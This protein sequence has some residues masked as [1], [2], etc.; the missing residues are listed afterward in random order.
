M[1]RTLLLQ[2]TISASIKLTVSFFLAVFV[3]STLLAQA[4]VLK[5]WDKR[6]G[7][8]D[9]DG[10]ESIIST[11][12]GGYLVGGRS[13][14]TNDGDKTEPETTKGE[15]DYWVVKLNADGTKAWD[16]TYG[17]TR[18]DNLTA[19]TTTS[20]GGYLLGGYSFSSI[21]ANRTE[22]SRGNGDFW[23]V[24]INAT[25]TKIWDKR[26]GGNG[27]DLLSS[28]VS[29]PDGGFLAGGSSD[30]NIGGDKTE[31]SNGPGDFWLL[32]L[33]EDGTKVW[34]KSYGG[35]N[36]DEII[37]IVPSQD[38]GYLLGGW[39]N[40]MATGSKS[41]NTKGRYDYWFVK[42]N[43]DGTKVWDKSIGGALNE[44]L[45]TLTPTPDGGYLAGGV[46]ES[47][48]GA[49]ITENSKGNLDYWAVKLDATGNKSWDK[50]FGGTGFDNLYSLI[51]TPDG[52]YLLGGVSDS[53]VGTDKTEPT[54]GSWDHWIIKLDSNGNKLWDKT[55]G[56]DGPEESTILVLAEDGFV[57]GGT[58]ESGATGDKTKTSRGD[59]DYWI[60]KMGV[61]PVLGVK[62][63]N[64]FENASTSIFPNP[65]N[66]SFTLAIDGM[67]DTTKD[68]LAT[69]TNSL[70]LPVLEQKIS[71]SQA[72]KGIPISTKNLSKGVYYL[73]LKIDSSTLTKKVVIE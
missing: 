22:D 51:V 55:I 50:R 29:T 32:K 41:E 67:K 57:I 28:L 25:G 53:G 17:G 31:N 11:P 35:S 10:F 16:K 13:R 58:S 15:F 14:S 12:D 23:I 7:G 21:G 39:S 62:D 56:G 47:G 66:G 5:Q 18:S 72:Q 38:G 63:H 34:D 45:F 49:D 36:A 54:V 40:S 69:L 73:Q 4:P 46:S 26:F 19:L 9:W 43:S 60:I 1:N 61:T 48:A 44:Y 52:G 65:S 71:R 59:R 20:D 70:G 42:I 30:S 2:K 27:N 37:S 68:I 24:K 8:S 6:Y 64:S 33:T 3:H